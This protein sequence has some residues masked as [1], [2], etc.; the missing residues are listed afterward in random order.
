MASPLGTDM[1]P[2]RWIPGCCECLD[3][4]FCL[5]D[6]DE[7][8]SSAVG[9]FGKVG[10]FFY[11]GLI[12]GFEA[13]CHTSDCSGYAAV[14]CKVQSFDNGAGEGM[15]DGSGGKRCPGSGCGHQDSGLEGRK[16]V[17]EM[18]CGQGAPIPPGLRRTSAFF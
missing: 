9:F 17:S 4:G 18:I 13:V 1:A 3:H 8:F 11:D 14:E 5:S 12:L 7:I 6:F 2:V 10:G 15:S 16:E